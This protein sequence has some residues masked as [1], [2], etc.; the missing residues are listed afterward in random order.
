MIGMCS[1]KRF[2][3]FGNI[4]KS[5]L[6][7]AKS[8]HVSNLEIYAGTVPTNIEHN[9]TF[10]MMNRLHKVIKQRAYHING[11]RVF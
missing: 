11:E 4:Q 8:R 3:T 1:K 5:V 7:E 10:C 9:M 6:Q 2:R